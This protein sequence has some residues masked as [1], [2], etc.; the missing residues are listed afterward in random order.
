MDTSQCDRL[1]RLPEVSDL[2]TV[3]KSTINAWVAQGK[4]PAPAVLSPTIKVWRKSD[5][6][7][8][9]NGHFGDFQPMTTTS[10]QS[11]EI[12][13]SLTHPGVMQ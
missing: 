4:F 1:L 12:S 13:K 10:D 3:G 5:V 8:W 2:T 6:D 7:T 9:I 11:S